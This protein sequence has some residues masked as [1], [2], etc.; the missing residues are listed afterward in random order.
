[1]LA[2]PW[3][4]VVPLECQDPGP[5]RMTLQAFLTHMAFC[6][7]LA[8]LSA[9]VVALMLRARV[10]DIPDARKAHDR[11]IPKGGGV[12]VVAAFLAGV[13]ALYLFAEFSRLAEPFFRGVILG[14]VAIAVVSFIDDV[15]D[16]P[17]RLR[18]LAQL[19]AASVAVASGLWVD[20]VA[21]PVA[22]VVEL[23]WLGVPATLFFIVFV[24]NAVNFMDGLNGLVAGTAL[25][26]CAGLAVVAAGQGG[27]FVYFAALLL[28]AGCVGFLPFNFPR[29]RIF[30]GDVGSQFL[31]FMLAVLGIAAA[32][33][34]RVELSF[35]LVPMLLA[36]L[37]FDV[38]F[39]LV[40]RALAREPLMQSHRGHLYQVAHRTG[41][42]AR[43]IAL[44]HW[45]FAG[46]GALCAVAF[47]AA[48]SPWKAFWAA[49]P[50]APQLAW[51]GYV[52]WRGRALRPW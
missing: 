13:V 32:R 51:L 41:M 43:A 44:L 28:A 2:L 12:G 8:L 46:F 21:L 49:L 34:E 29:A 16:L 26:A 19:A 31:G 45:G 47:V 9:A 17:A 48:A 39:T 42:D 4:A 24:T 11:P 30:M 1:M 5:G 36:G 38:A 22:G 27:W 20:R 15:R 52:A 14:A 35:A 10:M 37:L 18:L 23:G 7:A 50:F 6:A 33:F 25:V 40:R 3:R